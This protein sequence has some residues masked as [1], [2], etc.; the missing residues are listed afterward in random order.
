M[1]GLLTDCHTH[2]DQYPPSELDGVVVRARQAGLGAI[3]LAGVTLDSSA[4]CVALAES[5]PTLFAGVG[6]HPMDVREPLDDGAY[7]R[8]RDLAQ[9]SP[10]VVAVSETG[11]DFGPDG[12]DAALQYHAFRQQVRLARELRL[13]IIFHSRELPGD[14]EAHR[15]VFRL[16]REERGWEVGGIMHYFQS[17]WETAQECMDLG[18]CVS[19]GKPLLRLPELQDVAAKLPLEAIVLETDAAPQ[20]FKAKRE[21]WTE[22]RDTRLVADRLA[23]LRGVS[24]GEIARAT[25]DNLMRLYDRIGAARPRALLAQ[26][27]EGGV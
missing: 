1:Q 20:P 14:T 5:H 7:S 25:N 24:T 9:S 17:T 11:L 10:R 6:I 23:E 3:I 2:L 27:L 13:P 8:L 12:A 21:N 16:L 4:R 15:E 26:A 19:L 22:P 18:F